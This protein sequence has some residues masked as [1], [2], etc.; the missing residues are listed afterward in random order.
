M[1]Q[2]VEQVTKQMEH[3]EIDEKTLKLANAEKDL[4][5][6]NAYKHTVTQAIETIKNKSNYAETKIN[7]NINI[8]FIEIYNDTN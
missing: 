6:T 8:Q 3:V 4:G 1:A 2:Q 7:I 5:K